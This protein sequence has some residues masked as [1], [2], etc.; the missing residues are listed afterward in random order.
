MLNL[1]I[2]NV[3]NMKLPRRGINDDDD[4]DDAIAGADSI[5]SSTGNIT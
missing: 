4:D 1:F 5:H 3:S 2:V